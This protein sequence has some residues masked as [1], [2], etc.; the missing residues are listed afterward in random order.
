MER[1]VDGYTGKGTYTYGSGGQ[2]AGE[3]KD[4]KKD[5]QGTYTYGVDGTVEKGL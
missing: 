5:G 1:I 4:G 3:W 2:Y